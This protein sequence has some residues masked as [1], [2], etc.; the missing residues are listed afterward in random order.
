M[1][2]T[3]IWTIIVILLVFINSIILIIIWK[4]GKLSPP[5]GNQ[6]EVKDFLVKQLSLSKSQIE[7][8]EALREAHHRMIENLDEKN[9][10]L[11][12]SLFEN[13]GNISNDPKVID[14]LTNKI[15]HNAALMDKTT[16]YH[17][18]ELRQI[19]QPAQ[20]KKLD[21]II[22]QVLQMLNHPAPPGGHGPGR[23]PPPPNGIRPGNMPPP[24]YDGARPEKDQ[25]PNGG[26][27]GSMPPGPPPQG[28]PYSGN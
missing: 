18:R 13:L 4:Q 17:F 21:E 20:Q 2:T 16:F 6:M 7:K 24:P 5:T 10:S 11:K 8:F 15:G 9:R 28:Q 23:M 26:Q 22:V 19:L 12:D 27:P 1:K 14:T 3:N 25:A